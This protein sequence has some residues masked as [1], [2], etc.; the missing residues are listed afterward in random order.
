M[1]K[2]EA[3]PEFFLNIGDLILPKDI[4]SLVHLWESSL[5][6]QLSRWSS[7]RKLN[8]TEF[9]KSKLLDHF[10]KE[11]QNLTSLK[12]T[13][14]SEKEI[15]EQIDQIL[16]SMG[17]SELY[18][19]VRSLH[20]KVHFEELDKEAKEVTKQPIVHIKLIL[21]SFLDFLLLQQKETN[22][23][24]E[25]ITKKFEEFI[26]TAVIRLVSTVHPNE[27]ERGTN[28]LHYNRI[29]EKFI[30]WRKEYDAI[31]YVDK[32]S[33]EYSIR[34]S[35]VNGMRRDIKSEM[36]GIWQSDQMRDEKIT[37]QSEGRRIMERYQ[38][39]FKALPP[40]VKFAKQIAREAFLLFYASHLTVSHPKFKETFESIFQN[41][42]K[43]RTDR[44]ETIKKTLTILEM[45]PKIP[46]L[47]APII[48]FGTWKGGDRDGNPYVVA[49]FTNQTLIEHKEFTLEK[50]LEFT[51]R[52]IDMLTASLDHV[53]CNSD[54]KESVETEKNFFPYIF[55][56]KFREIY[57]A[58]VRYITEKLT[59]TL[60]LTKQIKKQA[61]ESTKP[62]LS[63]TLPGPT[64]YNTS[65]QLLEDINLLYDS[66]VQNEGKAQARSMMQD[67]KILVETFGF[68]LVSLDFR[69]TS[70]TNTS[71]L[72]EY[73]TFLSLE[74]SSFTNQTEEQKRL[75]LMNLLL[76]DIT[77]DPYSLSNLSKES[78]ETFQS[79]IILADAQKTNPTAI[80]K[81]I[82]SMTSDLSD[83]LVLMVL[84]KL[85][86]LLKI[87]NGKIIGQSDITGLYETIH[88]L[89]NAPKII[90]AYFSFPE[91]K[92]YIVTQRNGG[93][94]AMLGYSDSTRDGS[95]MCSDANLISTTLS[96]VE[97]E[98]K[99]NKDSKDK[100]H[101]LF[102]RGR[103]D[104]IPRGF[105]GNIARSISS[106]GVNSIE[107]HHTEQNRFLRKYATVPSAMDHLNAIYR[108]HLSALVT[109]LPNEASTYQTIF[110]F[111]GNLSFMK[112]NQLVR[113]QNNGNG[114]IYF[115]ML[116]KY[117]VLPILS[118]CNFASRPVCREG[119]KYNVENIRAIPFT[120]ILAQMRDF[121]NGYYGV[122]T[123]F[124]VGTKLLTNI[125]D[126]TKLLVS[127][128]YANKKQDSLKQLVSDKVDIPI[129]HLINKVLDGEVSDYQM[130]DDNLTELIPIYQ[131]FEVTVN[132]IS[133]IL[134][135]IHFVR[136]QSVLEILQSI[137]EK[138]LPFQ[139]SIDNK[140]T[141][142]LIRNYT[143][144]KEYAKFATEDEKKVLEE[145]EKEAILSKEWI[146]KITKNEKL[147]LKPELKDFDTPELLIL[148]KIQAR[149]LQEYFKDPKNAKN[150]VLLT[151]LQMTILSISEGLGFGG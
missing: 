19:V 117:T 43:T 65:D 110:E 138:Y 93:L 29:L 134:L 83:I 33:T 66:L 10:N 59:N 24:M 95:S 13:T 111:F 102:Y 118:T 6:K 84:L 51:T 72:R 87:Q 92:E 148:H 125:K 85:V 45:K 54:L 68:H 27:T 122:G 71:T 133:T 30:D 64:G 146:L 106:Q 14:T 40:I 61:G 1:D 32:Y 89:Q 4:K 8:T 34:R 131:S 67:F 53:N 2:T 136:K 126:T 16:D 116:Q 105:S 81:Y 46:R 20:L 113:T 112:W 127:L 109:K 47:T 115:D 17:N 98:K 107:E 39:I 44:M 37:V 77:F 63:L 52:L 86:G 141:A 108:S 57:R 103:G 38:V 3:T 143:I 58:K 124:Q 137:Y 25:E 41:T 48:S 130:H 21:R 100:I 60:E 142:L 120:M 145:C 74:E 99:L 119:V 79:L 104:T 96:L 132:C 101:I 26:N 82:I 50:Y 121:T 62:L 114:K 88:D 12:A 123:S 9:L 70:T 7:I 76:S 56:I 91:L 147:R 78:K 55:N 69:Q 75:T 15:I 11:Y 144:V 150:K 97:L 80:G 28:L 18:G 139:C 94:T 151:Q 128:Y 22:G 90:E 140:E 31:Q 135:D 35:K 5:P 49:A 149:L 36:E 129:V 23:N 73:L 42:S